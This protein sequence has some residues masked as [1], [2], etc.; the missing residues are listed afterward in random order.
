M[1]QTF[2]A[3]QAGLALQEIK[4][5]SD[6]INVKLILTL[7]ALGAL[8]IL[9]TLAPVKRQLDKLLNKKRD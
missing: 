9:P 3:V 5:P 1:P 7:F 6:I 2:V 4:S 8:S